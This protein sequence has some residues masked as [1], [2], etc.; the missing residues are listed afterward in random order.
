MN[1]RL[2]RASSIR[3]KLESV[4]APMHLDIVN[5]SHMH[6]G[7][8]DAQT[9]FK[10]VISSD[11]FEQK[12]RVARHQLVYQALDDEFANGLHALAL[13]IYTVSEWGSRQQVPQS[14]N[15]MG[16]SKSNTH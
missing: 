9:H 3:S 10:V 15:C 1:N 2:D 5:E 8:A 11:A 6:S 14:P 12:S 16:G 13:H 7:P 4:F